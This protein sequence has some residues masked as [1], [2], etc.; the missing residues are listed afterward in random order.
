MKCKSKTDFGMPKRMNFYAASRFVMCAALLYSSAAIS[1]VL[2]MKFCT[3]SC[4]VCKPSDA[5]KV[6]YRAD[7][8]KNRVVRIMD[9]RDIHVVS[10]CTVI[11]KA[12]W[13]CDGSGTL[14]QYGKQFAVNGVANWT[15]SEPMPEFE[16]VHGKFRIC[17]YDKNIIGQLKLRR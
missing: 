6:E 9:E 13:T 14:K 3:E 11:D 16:R 2:Y 4:D 5:I 15:D 12:N 7:P 10:D 8:Q 1:Q 17:R